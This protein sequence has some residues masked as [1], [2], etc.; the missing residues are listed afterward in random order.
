MIGAKTPREAL[1]SDVGMKSSGD[2]LDAWRRLN[3]QQGFMN[4]HYDK[5]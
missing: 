2:D 5:V 3:D 1:S 4:E